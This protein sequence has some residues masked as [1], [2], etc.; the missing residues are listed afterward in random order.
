[1]LR[2]PRINPMGW[3]Q[4][5][6]ASEPRLPSRQAPPEEC[7]GLRRNLLKVSSGPFCSHRLYYHLLMLSLLSPQ[8]K[9]FA[10]GI[11]LHS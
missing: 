1:M 6:P 2:Q 3:K 7:G 11:L 4:W 5:V 9:A 8:G 10:A